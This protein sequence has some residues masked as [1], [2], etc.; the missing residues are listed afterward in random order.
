MKAREI[1][2]IISTIEKR[3]DASLCSLEK[4]IEEILEN[5]DKSTRYL[6]SRIDKNRKEFKKYQNKIDN[7]FN[8]INEAHKSRKHNFSRSSLVV[9]GKPDTENYV[10]NDRIE[11]LPKYYR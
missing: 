3:V 11:P 10:S 7:K 5:F 1:N 2:T 9:E 8:S 6:E 4:S